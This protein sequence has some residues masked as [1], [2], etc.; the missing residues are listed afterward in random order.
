M[1][2]QPATPPGLPGTHEQ[3]RPDQPLTKTKLKINTKR[4]L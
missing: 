1:Y 3:K 2:K 4:H